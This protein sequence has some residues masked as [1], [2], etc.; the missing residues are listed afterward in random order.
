MLFCV[1]PRTL[2][3][4]D[5]QRGIMVH[6]GILNISELQ[7]WTLTIRWFSVIS[8]TIVGERFDPFAEILSAYSTVLSDFS[9]R[10]HRF[11]LG[12]W[13][14]VFFF[15]CFRPPVLPENRNKIFLWK[16]LVPAYSANV[17]S[18]WVFDTVIYFD[19]EM[20]AR[21]YRIYTFKFLKQPSMSTWS[22]TMLEKSDPWLTCSRNKEVIN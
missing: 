11:Q 8:G 9:F 1:V 10:S 12:I 21:K 17:Q 13:V 7:D 19:N 14:G 4:C 18:V 16:G 22:R 15:F 3:L 6:H 2:V 20:G 5:L